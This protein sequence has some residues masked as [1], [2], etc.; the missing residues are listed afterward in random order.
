MNKCETIDSDVMSPIK[1]KL[2]AARQWSLLVWHLAD[3][4]RPMSED[5]SLLLMEIVNLVRSSS[6]Q[7]VSELQGFIEEDAKREE[8]SSGSD[9]NKYEDIIGF[10]KEIRNAKEEHPALIE[11]ARLATEKTNEAQRKLAAIGEV[12]GNGN[13]KQLWP[14]GLTHAEAIARIIKTLKLDAMNKTARVF[15]S[16]LK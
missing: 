13:D 6:P 7:E 1:S 2:L 4:T 10:L 11:G 9:E 14:D 3:K 5:A 12:L 16:E 8:R 15:Y